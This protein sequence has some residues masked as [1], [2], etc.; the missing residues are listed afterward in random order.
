M[1]LREKKEGKKERRKGRRKGGRKGRRK[2]RGGN[3]RIKKQELTSSGK[4]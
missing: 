1:M 2:E 4:R 3:K